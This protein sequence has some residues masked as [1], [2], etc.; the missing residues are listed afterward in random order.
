MS[1]YDLKKT[2][3]QDYALPDGSAIGWFWEMWR[4]IGQIFLQSRPIQG[5][6]FFLAVLVADAGLG[7]GLLLGALWGTILARILRLDL[8]MRGLGLYGFSPALIGLF[9]MLYFGISLGSIGLI[10]LGGLACSVITH[11]GVRHRTPPLYALPFVLSAWAMVYLGKMYGVAQDPHPIP[12]FGAYAGLDL[13]GHPLIAQALGGL[14]QVV[15][16]TGMISGILALL[17]LALGS[18]WVAVVAFLASLT[19]ACLVW[20]LGIPVPLIG[21][22]GYNL[23]LTAIA[24]LGDSIDL[25]NL[26]IV[27]FGVVL[28]FL[29]AHTLTLLGPLVFYQD[30]GGFLTLPFVFA[31]WAMRWV[32]SSIR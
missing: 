3:W 17:G 6:V 30:L 19:G 7:A 10:L 25:T 27:G 32:G 4:G 29:W 26:V 8:Q 22:A 31:T 23:V 2:L 24:L 28:A 13:G 21:L 12:L 1:L 5:M 9:M 18:V 14:G 11:L 16:Q 20:H 15:F